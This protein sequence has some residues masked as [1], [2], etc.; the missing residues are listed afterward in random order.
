MLKDS[1]NKKKLAIVSSYNELCGNAGYTKALSQT[2]SNHFDVTVIPLN[3]ELLRKKESKAAQSHLTKIC[4]ELQA[5]D[6]V[7]IQFE[8]GL[9]GIN[10]KKIY[11]R[12]FKIAK[13]C[14]KLV[15]TMHRVDYQIKYPGLLSIGKNIL[16]GNFRLIKQAFFNALINNRYAKTYNKVVHYCKSKKI[17]IIVH[18]KRERED[19]HFHFDYDL[20][21]DHPLSFY[22]QSY[23]ESLAKDNNREQFCK[24][25]NLPEENIYLGILGF[26]SQYKGYE[27][28][29]QTMALLPEKYNLIIFGKQHP[30]TI[31]MNE[32]VNEY[33]KSLMDTI[34][35]LKIEKRVRFFGLSNDEDFLRALLGCDFNLLPYLEVNQGGSG[36]AA[37]SLETNSKAIFSQ[38]KTFLEL[39]K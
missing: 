16:K 11:Q 8:A 34:L 14:K 23:I 24:N 6:C 20:V 31:R 2:L 7:N 13:S 1:M 19:I 33:I 18:S 29:L 30:H 3:V 35:K 38:N 26:I 28:V 9:Y 10:Y 25:F 5:F 17:P 27:T 22:E 4:N 39:E 37:L 32:Q 36:I 15:L 21:F 12:F